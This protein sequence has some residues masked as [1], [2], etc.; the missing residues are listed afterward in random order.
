MKFG[1]HFLHNSSQFQSGSQRCALFLT[2]VKI[3][4][5]FWQ[6]QD[7]ACA[8]EFVVS[9]DFFWTEKDLLLLM[10]IHSLMA[11]RVFS[12]LPLPHLHL[13]HF[14]LHGLKRYQSRRSA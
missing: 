14:L 6:A 13:S 8:F 10:I 9:S 5:R 1:A 4:K 3:I 12:A 2:L 11:A 7:Y